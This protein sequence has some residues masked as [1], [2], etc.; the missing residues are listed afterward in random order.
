MIKN[1]NL[2]ISGMHCDS[3]E[4]LIKE[5]LSEIS[6]VKV[7]RIDHKTGKA[8]LHLEK[9][10]IQLD[11]L[12]N[13]V[14]RAGYQAV[15]EANG[16]GYGKSTHESEV[17]FQQEI[18]AS[19]KPF[20][21]TIE[22]EVVAEGRISQ[23]AGGKPYFDGIVKNNKNAKLSIPQ[24]QVGSKNFLQELISSIDIVKLFDRV[25]FSTNRNDSD[26]VTPNT[27]S[28][29]PQNS[30]PIK[31][32]K[33]NTLTANS[34]QRINLS[35][36]GMHCSSCAALIEKSL[37]KVTGVS[38]ANVNFAA[39]KA[40][41][42]YDGNIVTVDSLINAVKKAGYLASEVKN[43]D[44]EFDRKK[45]EK[46][47]K[48]LSEAFIN[49]LILSFPML[50]FMLFDFISWI[51]G[52]V[53]LTP[54]IGIISLLLSTPVQF[55]IG[56]RFYKGM[57][58]AL[59]MKTFNMDSL[60][61]I[62]TSTA[63]FYSLIN[64]V[65]YFLKTGSLIGIN[66]AKIPELYFETAAFLITFVI[67]GKWLEIRAKGRTS[68]A[69]K[70]LMGLAA[71]TAR[72]V[73]DG[74]T[75]DIPINEV[76]AGDIILV[77]PGEKV[78][79]DGKI[80]K[81]SSSVDESMLTGESIPVEKHEG[82][83][84]VGAT[85]N[86]MGSFEFVATRVGSETTLAQIIRLIEEAQG[87]K[88][89]IQAFADKISAWFVPIVIGIA[90][91]TFII[92]YFVLGATLAFALMAFTSVIVIACPCAVGLATPTALMVGT[93]KGAE[94]GVLIKGGEPLE[95]ACKV[96]TVVFDKTGTLTN[97]KPV[98]TDIVGIGSLNDN[99]VLS[100]SAS[101]EKSSEHP[102]AE[103]IYNYAKEELATLKDTQNFKAIAG[104]GVTAEI[105]SQKYY[106][107]NRKLISEVVGLPIDI[108]DRKLGR[109]EEQGKTAMIL[110]NDKE[111]LGI[112]AVAD[113]VKETSKE[114]VAKLKKRGIEV[115]MI[116]GD[117]RRTAEAIAREVGID[118]VLAEVLPEDKASEVKKIQGM[119]KRVAMVGDGI[120]DAPALAQADIGVAMGNGTDVAMEAGGIV[121]MKNDLRDVV[122]AFDLSKET[123]GKIKQNMFFA[124][125]Y[126]VIGIPIAARA[127]ISLGLVLKPELA[128]L[129]M[130]FS[131]ISVVSNS[132]LLRY[133]RPGRRNYISMFAPIAMML[134]FTFFFFEFGRFS[135]SMVAEGKEM[136]ESSKPSSIRTL[137][138]DLSIYKDDIKVISEA[139]GDKV[140]Y[141]ISDSNI[142]TQYKNVLREDGFNSIYISGKTYIPVYIGSDEAEMMKE[143][144]IF[145]DPGDRIS[146]FFGNDVIVADILPK[147]DSTLDKFH[148]VNSS[149]KL[150][151]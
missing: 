62:G 81:G 44:P 13:A 49:S 138:N 15:I 65:Y 31:E 122:T 1:V 51:P 107:G 118:N 135:S 26:D 59:R 5:E 146:N 17:L 39:E 140:F 92:W 150:I 71:K 19:N 101:L 45:R 132:L 104:H 64:L 7:E 27:T 60:I 67:L 41:V 47:I 76:K 120:N 35:L 82:D 102:L 83:T 145:K 90:L 40:L 54:F 139:E 23:D 88:A 20:K 137:N 116:T 3:C 33:T 99:S 28:E 100:L 124:L 38:K 34:Q 86:K 142:P 32:E 53:M 131:S 144:K 78:P 110:S 125:F 111:I 57:W 94:Y 16:N 96:N 93:G 103:A 18:T 29:I 130:A 87:S 73:K 24:G 12:I 36:S 119:G 147:T 117:N 84:V 61:A 4:T 22:S 80:I 77:R 6:G 113:T 115:Y 14:K 43:N 37:K 108:V 10:N 9:E 134:F 50:Y 58:S 25:E 126:N 91:L 11:E 8:L 148:F 46:E 56:L 98:V 121:I 68:D 30:L 123:M 66:G 128:G 151:N 63:Y 149:F 2:T 129:A 55:I 141:Y 52:K 133:F 89:P 105:D 70:K 112:V 69:I 48:G 97:G 85:M 75:M 106:F 127:L 79:I 143:K 42:F 109:L 136:K 72:V 95:S 114:A 74:Q 21:I